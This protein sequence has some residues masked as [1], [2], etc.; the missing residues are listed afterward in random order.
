MNLLDIGNNV[1][2]FLRQKA[3]DVG[4]KPLKDNSLGANLRGIGQAGQISTNFAQK[5]VN[6][7]AQPAY[8]IPIAGGLVKGI[9]NQPFNYASSGA[10]FLQNPN[11]KTGSSFLGQGLNTASMFVAPTGLSFKA[12]QRVLPQIPNMAKNSFLKIGL[13]AGAGG[14]LDTYSKGGNA[15]DILSS[16]AF[17][18]AVG[19]GA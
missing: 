10:Q 3:L 7:F 15:K 2:N 11:V 13:P 18:T 17:N 4:F 12:G 19:S 8:N 9:I 14:V 1:R 5:Q 16:F 6:N